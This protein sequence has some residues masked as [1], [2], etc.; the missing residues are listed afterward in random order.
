MQLNKHSGIGYET[1][2]PFLSLREG[3]MYKYETSAEF[4]SPCVRIMDNIDQQMH[5]LVHTTPSQVIQPLTNSAGG[6]DKK[7]SKKKQAAVLQH[8]SAA[9]SE[10]DEQ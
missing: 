9:M 7:M 1:F 5:G 4:R 6:E 8:Q 10:S 3:Q 2:Y